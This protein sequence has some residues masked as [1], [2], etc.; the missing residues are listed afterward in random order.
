MANDKSFKIKNGL[1]ATRYLGTN[2]T[3]TAGTVNY[4]VSTASYDS[5]SFSHSEEGNAHS[6]FFKSDGTMFFITG[7]SG[8]DVTPFTMSTAWDLSTATAGTPFSVS[9]QT[10]VPKGLFFKSDGTKMY[11]AGNDNLTVYQYSLSTAWDVST[12]SY[13][14]KSF[15]ASGQVST[16]E[17]VYISPDGTKMILCGQVTDSVFEYDLSTAHDV[18]TASYNSVSL[19]VSSLTVAPREAFFVEDGYSL[20]VGGPDPTV[21]AVPLVLKYTA[22]TA[23][24]LSTVTLSSQGYLVDGFPG[25]FRAFHIKADGSKLYAM[26]YGGGTIY[27][28]STVGYTQT[29]DLSTGHTFSFTP[30][31]ATTVS[32]TNPPASGVATGFTVEVVGDGSAITWPSSVKWHLGT[33]PTATASKEVYTFITTDGGTTYYGKKAGE[34]LA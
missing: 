14:S 3:E 20:L 6:L 27:Q 5:I 9:S 22:T 12:A 23:Y 13:D 31:G 7:Q 10:T 8:D 34:N 19:D 21:D 28:Y 1:S 32:F 11:V 4:S 18:S 24:D 33:A 25:D 15:L 26:E 17:S 2:G 16:L 29:L 30:S